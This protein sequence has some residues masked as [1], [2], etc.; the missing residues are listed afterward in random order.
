MSLDGAYGFVYCGAVDLG[1]GAFIVENG[2]IR[3]RD[4]GGL[5]YSGTIQENADKTITSKIIYRIPTGGMLVQGVA[6]QD[7]PYD[8]VIEQIFPPL[9][10]DG[11]PVE[12]A[13]PPVTVM[14]RRLPANST[15]PYALGLS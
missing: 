11:K 7:V 13:T 6:P 14:I 3:G 8:K 15:L 12:T 2:A 4:S 9:F 1:I 10:G 5:T